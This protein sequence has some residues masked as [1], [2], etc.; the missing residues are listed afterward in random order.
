MV[1]N[2]KDSENKLRKT[3]EIKEGANL[4]ENVDYDELLSAAG[5][6]GPYQVI[7]FFSTFPFY[8]FGVFSYFSQ[9]FMTEVSP[10]HWCWIPELENLTDIERRTLAIPLDVDARFG[11]S[12]CK[13]Y[14]ANWSEILETGQTPNATWSTQAC[15]YGWEFNSSEI[16]YPTI[17]S[18][19]GW[20]CDKNSYQATAQSIFFTGSIV[21]GIVVGWVADRFGRLP[22][23]TLSN[24]IGCV[25]GILSIFAQN[26]IQF[27]LCRF[28]MGMSYDNCMMM[29]Y[30]LVL[31]YVAPRYRSIITNLPFAIFYTLGATALPWIALACG[32]WKTI[33][34][35]TS[36]PMA[37][38]I[39]APFVMPES[40]RW[41]I[42]KGRFNDAVDKVLTIARVNKKEIPSKLIEQFKKS[43]LNAKK[44]ESTS[45]LVL[46]KRPK[47]RKMFICICLEFMCCLAIFDALIR[48]IG[49]LGFDFFL[50]FTLVSFTELPSLVIVSFAI[51]ITG[52]KGMTII[53]FI[54][55]FIFCLATAFIS[56]GLP[57]VLCAVVSRFAINMCANIGMQWAAEMLPTPVR[58]SGSSIVHIFSYIGIV[59][60]PY[61]VYLDNY[62]T[63]LPL[64]VVAVI[65]LIGLLLALALP[66][67]AGI[68]MP[69]TFDEAEELLSNQKLI[70]IPFLR[71]KENNSRNEN[72]SVRDN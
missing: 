69:Q 27:S 55:C 33:S 36:I 64:V 44:E 43:S 24:M 49:G 71:K 15:Q 46:L 61:I 23:A 13:S 45:I 17:S 35:A 40:P 14:I 2:D 21:G 50:S 53:A 57:S 5:E 58:G 32:H 42:S 67:T 41:L 66:E 37:I 26:F 11:Y 34:L 68:D 28:I 8:I 52:R 72:I 29:T 22:A 30:L 63:W 16:P 38:T 12:Q 19:L 48:S 31:E 70:D 18:E 10:N 60:S 25:A 3:E 7:L 62:I 39:L 9:L 1:T 4:N 59:I 6:F 54:I 51:D 65:A 20:V 56:N 47:L